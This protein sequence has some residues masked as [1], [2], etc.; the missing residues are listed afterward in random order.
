MLLNDEQIRHFAEAWKEDFG[1]VLTL[2]EA[3]AEAMRLLEFF[4]QFAEGLE[5]IRSRVDEHTEV[6]VII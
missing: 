4:A 5:R 2:E 3:R 1:E 6:D